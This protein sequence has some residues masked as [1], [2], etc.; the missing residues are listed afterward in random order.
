MFANIFLNYF[1]SHIRYLQTHC[2][3]IPHQGI[4]AEKTNL[5]QYGT[6]GENVNKERTGFI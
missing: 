3:S 2:M 6:E 4:L 1:Y 5:V